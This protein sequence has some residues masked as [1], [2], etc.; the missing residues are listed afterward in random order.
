MAKTTA[1]QSKAATA[2]PAVVRESVPKID[3]SATAVEVIR[4]I[5]S[6]GKLADF[7]Q[8]DECNVDLKHKARYVE[9]AKR[10]QNGLANMLSAKTFRQA[11]VDLLAGNGE[12]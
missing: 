11:T 1:T 10:A 6:V 5:G 3:D 8:S 9:K 4:A 2:K 12:R 7:L